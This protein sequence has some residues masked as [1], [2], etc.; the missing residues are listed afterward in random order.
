MISMD[1][2]SSSHKGVRAW[3][4]RRDDKGR[5]R[6]VLTVPI[7]RIFIIMLLILGN[8]P[9][10]LYQYNRKVPHE[11][12]MLALCNS[13][14]TLAKIKLCM[15]QLFL[16]AI[17]LNFITRKLESWINMRTDLQ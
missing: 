8:C 2:L 5:K 10:V 4:E 15:I 9:I 6:R 3:E 7:Q 14:K 11:N 16:L 13:Q 17:K 1:W 12:T